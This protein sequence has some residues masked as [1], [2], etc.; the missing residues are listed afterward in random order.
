MSSILKAIETKYSTLSVSGLPPTLWFNDAP[1]K[2]PDNTPTNLPVVEFWN[3]S[4]QGIFTLEYDT[5]FSYQFLFTVYG[6]TEEETENIVYG[7]LYN[8]A[9]PSDAAG[10]AFG[11]IPLSSPWVFESFEMLP[12][13]P[14]FE[15]LNAT[16]TSAGVPAYLGQWR[17]VLRAQRIAP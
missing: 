9:A 5:I 11:T 7:I 12:T 4:T 2:N 16:R 1:L 10:F 13:G 6:N 3:E 14:V 17:Q 8:N 15:K